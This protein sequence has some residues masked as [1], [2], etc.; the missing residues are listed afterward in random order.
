MASG[1]L[2]LACLRGP[3]AARRAG[4]ALRVAKRTREIGAFRRAQRLPEIAHRAET[5][6]RGLDGE[7]LAAEALIDL[8]P[9]QRRRDAGVV[10]ASRAIRRRQRLA[11]DVL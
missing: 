4:V 11:E 3:G 2:A 7:I 6:G 1:S 5:V 8:A 10:A 9:G